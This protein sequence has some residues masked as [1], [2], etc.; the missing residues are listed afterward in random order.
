MICLKFQS[1][2][3]NAPSQLTNF[4]IYSDAGVKLK[5]I[6]LNIINI[7]FTFKF[8]INDANQNSLENQN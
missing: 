5:L 2:L 1:N 3:L 4:Q 7:N 8:I 6:K